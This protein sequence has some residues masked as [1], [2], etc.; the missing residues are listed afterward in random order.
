MPFFR[1]ILLATAAAFASPAQAQDRSACGGEAAPDGVVAAVTSARDLTLAD[2]R[3]VILAGLET[4]SDRGLAH[5]R[6]LTLG[7]DVALKVTEAK[8]DRYG[9][10]V[11]LIFLKG[12]AIPLQQLLLAQGQARLG[13]P[14]SGQACFTELLAHERRARLA[15]LGLWGDPV[16]AIKQADQPAALLADLG[17]FA[18][19]EGRVRSVRESRGIVY[20]N[21]GT[22]WTQDFA[23]TVR[24]RD[25]HAFAAAGLTLRDLSGRIVRVRGWIEARGGPRITATAPE[26]FELAERE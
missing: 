3:Q 19:V 4:D 12:A 7:K 9:R 20:V 25:Q 23:V 17:H 13:G 11:A 24:K 5:L 15:A 26:Q 6:Q 14:V 22:R 16:Y 10:V 21:F 1:C 18:I 8:A 2:G